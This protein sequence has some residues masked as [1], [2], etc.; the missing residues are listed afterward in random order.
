MRKFSILHLPAEQK[1]NQYATKCVIFNF[2]FTTPRGGKWI[3]LL[4]PGGKFPPAK[5][6]P[7]HP[8]MQFVIRTRTSL[9]WLIHREA[10]DAAIRYTG[11]P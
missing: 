9:H 6:R 8:F 2:V 3:L 4:S 7:V 5:E 10:P 1:Q 11:T